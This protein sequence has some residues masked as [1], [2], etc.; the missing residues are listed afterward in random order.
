MAPRSGSAVFGSEI[1]KP[2]AR[3]VTVKPP[4][5]AIASI[6]SRTVMSYRLIETLPPTPLPSTILMRALRAIMLNNSSMGV[7]RNVYDIVTGASGT[8][9]VAVLFVT[10]AGAAVFAAAGSARQAQAAHRA[11]SR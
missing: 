3:S 4:A 7:S 10:T 8:G 6:A 9:A 5:S 2:P 1:R 11:T